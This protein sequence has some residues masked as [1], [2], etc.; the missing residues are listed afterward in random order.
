MEGVNTTPGGNFLESLFTGVF[1]TFCVI[2]KLESLSP[3]TSG[4]IIGIISFKF[5][6]FL[7]QRILSSYR[8]PEQVPFAPGFLHP[9]LSLS[10][11]SY[12]FKS[13]ATR[14]Q[15]LKG[16][17]DEPTEHVSLVLLHQCG[18]GVTAIRKTKP[19]MKKPRSKWNLLWSNEQPRGQRR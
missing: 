10:N 11:C 19:G 3:P 4:L 5:F 8:R 1:D 14:L 7:L 17:V 6:T 2:F 13:A 9:G 15:A 18:P 16:V 12:T